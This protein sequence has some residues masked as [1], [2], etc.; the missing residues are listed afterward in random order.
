[1]P[2]DITKI[3]KHKGINQQTGKLKKGYKYSGKK[4]KNGLPQIIKINNNK[5]QQSAGKVLGE[6]N[7]GCVVSPAYSCDNNIIKNKVSKLSNSNKTHPHPNVYKSLKKIKNYQN[8]FIFPQKTCEINT[9]NINI[10]DKNNCEQ[11]NLFR[12]KT[13]SNSIMEK[14]DFDLSDVSKTNVFTMISYLYK[15]L[16]SIKLLTDNNIAHLDIKPLNIVIKNNQPFIIDFDDNFNPQNWVEYSKFIHNFGYMTDTYIWPPETY[17]SFDNFYRN[18]PTYISNYMDNID[19]YQEF[20]EKIMIF[21]LGLAFHTIFDS[22]KK[23]KNKPIMQKLINNMIEPDP[24]KRF[25]I[26]Q[27]INFIK[28]KFNFTP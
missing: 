1:M 20:I 6:G 10:N 16:Q 9:N 25:N 12:F 5:K 22:I 14:G 18:T 11:V 19:N 28:N 3:R 15:L 4:L 26:K 24:Q 17:Y 21:E 27:S 23:S 8:Y 2:S 13:I 7:Y